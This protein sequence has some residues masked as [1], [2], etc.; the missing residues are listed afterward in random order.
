MKIITTVGTSIFE[1]YKK[2]KQNKKDTD[3]KT[4]F[5]KIRDDFSAY[6]NWNECES[7][8]KSLEVKV[9]KW[10]SSKEDSSAEIASILKIAGVKKPEELKEKVEVVLL[11][12]DTVLSKLACDLIYEWFKPYGDFQFSEHNIIDNQKK[13]KYNLDGK[14]FVIQ[15]LRISNNTKYEQGFMRL[16]EVLD[17]LK[18]NENDVLNITGGYKAII[19]IMTIYG[20]LKNVPLNYIYDESELGKTDVIKV[21]SLPIN[22]DTGIAE[23]YTFHLDNTYLS[24]EEKDEEVVNRLKKWRLVTSDNQVSVFGRLFR[25]LMDK[26]IE[27][28]KSVLG[29]VMELKLFQFF[30]ETPSAFK[31]KSLKDFKIKFQGKKIGKAGFDIDLYFTTENQETAF[32]EVKSIKHL[33]GNNRQN[34]IDDISKRYKASQEDEINL[35]TYIL[36]F[37]KADFQ[38]EKYAHDCLKEMKKVSVELGIVFYAYFYDIP[39]NKTKDNFSYQSFVQNKLNKKLLKPYSIV[40]PLE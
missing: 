18:L 38:D 26:N 9:K 17:D 31:Q 36:I 14:G 30:H 29:A 1:N 7:R 16:I 37:Y 24:S 40:L 15:N 33:S 6:S 2:D 39:V 4:H 5:E 28:G 32:C 10:Y 3:F 25:N 27:G 19:P 21:E 11:S 34:Y 22:Y 12:T 13:H 23:L 20:Q 8:R 35:T